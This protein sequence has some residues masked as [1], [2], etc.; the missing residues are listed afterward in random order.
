MP[1]HIRVLSASNLLV[2]TWLLVRSEIYWTGPRDT[3][4]GTKCIITTTSQ[5]QRSINTFFLKSDHQGII[6]D[7]TCSEDTFKQGSSVPNFYLTLRKS[8][9]CDVITGKLLKC[10]QSFQTRIFGGKFEI[11]LKWTFDFDDLMVNLIEM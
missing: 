9:R 11:K 6:S 3:I 1:L 8:T 7:W 10:C 5:Q 2:N 4:C